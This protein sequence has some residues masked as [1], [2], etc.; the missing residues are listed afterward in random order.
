MICVFFCPPYHQAPA[1]PRHSLGGGIAKMVALQIPIASRPLAIAFASPGVQD[2][3]RVLFG[4]ENHDGPI[5]TR[6]LS[7][8]CYPCFD[9]VSEH[10]GGLW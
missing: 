8:S 7:V 5:Q 2:A 1:P 4:H 3:A 10:F 6:R 9:G